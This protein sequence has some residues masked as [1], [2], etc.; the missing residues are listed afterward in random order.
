MKIAYV[1][2]GLWLPLTGFAQIG[3]RHVYDFLNLMPSARLVA[4]GG[5]NV[6]LKDDDVH[7]AAMNPALAGD[8]MHQRAV[9]SFSNYLSDIRYGYAGYSHTFEGIGSFHSGIQYLSYGQMQ[10][11]DEFGN[12]TGTFSASDLAWVVGYS[13]SFG[14]F[15]AGANLRF[16]SSTIAT[17]NSAGLSVDLGGAYISKDKLFSAGV[18]MRN[19]GV[20]LTTFVTGGERYPLPFELSAGIS[21]KLRYMPLRFSITATNL[22]HPNL[23]LRDPDAVPEL[24]LSGNPVPEKNQFVDNLFRHA[25]FGGEF[26]MGKALRLRFGYNHLRR[27]ELRSDNRGGFSGFSLGAGIRAGGLAFDYGFASYGVNQA[28]QIHQF[29]LMYHIGRKKAE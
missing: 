21:Q 14:Q 22:D 6:S 1:L 3:G 4:M 23:I 17:Y 15:S 19:A 25:V 28:F 26:L 5:A 9:L 7:F 10:G 13:R 8:S 18:A 12:L 16:I 2:L 11:A 24:D 27:Q 29:S 20:Q